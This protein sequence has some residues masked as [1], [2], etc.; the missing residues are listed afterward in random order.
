M[1]NPDEPLDGG[2]SSIEPLD[3]EPA[4]TFDPDKGFAINQRSVDTLRWYSYL[5][6]P[7]EDGEVF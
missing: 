4:C 6:N 5:S 1:F 7:S 2:A 3:D